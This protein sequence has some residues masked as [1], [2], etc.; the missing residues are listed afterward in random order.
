MP[1]TS[2]K[3]KD[4]DYNPLEG[5][6]V[7]EHKRRSKKTAR[8]QV[9]G[10]I[11]KSTGTLNFLDRNRDLILSHHQQGVKPAAIA[12]MLSA[13]LKR[14]GAVTNKQVSNWLYQRK[15]SGKVKTRP[16]CSANGNLKADEDDHGCML[17]IMNYFFFL[18][19]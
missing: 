10:A 13:Q 19:I 14:P 12:L 6:M 4:G 15:K 8:K 2:S 1:R 3:G 5:L 9:R 11:S 7:T 16:V 18:C 17:L